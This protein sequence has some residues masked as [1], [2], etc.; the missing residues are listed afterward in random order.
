MSGVGESLLRTHRYAEYR[1]YR[2]RDGN[3]TYV[4]T[5]KTEEAIVAKAVHRWI[6]SRANLLSPL[7]VTAGVG[8]AHAENE[9]L[10]VTQNFSILASDV[11]AAR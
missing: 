11:L 3:E 6:E 7:Y 2:K 4:F 9:A 8:V 5:W 10:F 1:L